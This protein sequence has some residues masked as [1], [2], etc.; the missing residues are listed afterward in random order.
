LLEPET[1]QPFGY[2]HAELRV[3]PTQRGGRPPL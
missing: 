1:A 2:I 3:M